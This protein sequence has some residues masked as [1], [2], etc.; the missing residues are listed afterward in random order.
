MGMGIRLK[1][2]KLMREYN[3]TEPDLEVGDDRFTLRLWREP[4]SAH[5][6]D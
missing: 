5:H 6:P 2:I 1:I 4:V 3:G